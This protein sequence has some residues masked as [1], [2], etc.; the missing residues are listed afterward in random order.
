[1]RGGG[2]AWVG[3]KGPI[4]FREPGSTSS[5]FSGSWGASSLILGAG[6]HQNVIL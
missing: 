6:D 2:R 1:M 3:E 4:Y 5:Y